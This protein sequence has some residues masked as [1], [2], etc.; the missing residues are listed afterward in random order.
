MIEVN[1][2]TDRENLIIMIRNLELGSRVDIKKKPKSR[3]T[4]TQNAALHKY[5]SLLSEALNDAGYDMKQVLKNDIDI[6]WTMENAKE[7]L[8]RPI[9]KSVIGKDS[10]TKANTSEYSEIHNVLSRHLSEKLGVYI[11]WPNKRG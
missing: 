8:W 10:T 9:Q 7:H 6:P 2:E 11:P 5:L 4:M 3:R 1:T